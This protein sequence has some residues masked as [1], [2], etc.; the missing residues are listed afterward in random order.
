[1]PLS[2]APDG[3][4]SAQEP[5]AVTG[6]AFRHSCGSCTGKHSRQSF[7]ECEKH[8]RNPGT[9][10]H[11]QEAQRL[12]SVAPLVVRKALRDV[13]IG[14]YSVPAG[15][16]L[17]LHVFAMHTT[18]ANWPRP[19]AFLP[20]RALRPA[21]VTVLARPCTLVCRAEERMWGMPAEL[22]LLLKLCSE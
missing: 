11:T 10:C 12:Y 13:R 3:P 4:F 21:T 15:T 20:V 9:L 16:C 2:A 5:A 18:S 7:Y 6:G 19:D 22:L 8:S 17:L 14:R 1:M